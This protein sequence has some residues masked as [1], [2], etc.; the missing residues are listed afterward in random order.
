[1]LKDF[2]TFLMRGN[3]VD[4]AIGVVIGGAFGK[5]I[6]SLVSDI[7]MPPIGLVM[8]GVNFTELFIDL[9]G[10]G[11]ES[12]AKA[13]EAGA[14]TIN[15]GMFLNTM[16]DF[17]IV[18]FV[19]FMVVKAYTRLTEKPPAPSPVAAPTSKDCPYCLTAI[20]IKASKCAH[21][22]SDVK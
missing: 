13:K 8:G 10:V 2:K 14:P 4:M 3:V 15:Y 12:L 17:V 18:A 9:S 1:M 22:T 11:Y 6:S 21:C 5:I 16:I 19:I 7:L 20:P